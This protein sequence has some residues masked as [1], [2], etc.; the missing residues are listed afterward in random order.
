MDSFMQPSECYFQ[1]QDNTQSDIGA[2]VDAAADEDTMDCNVGTQAEGPHY[3]I[4]DVEEGNETSGGSDGSDGEGTD[5]NTT[6]SFFALSR[7]E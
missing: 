4:D 5:K 3:Y 6:G 1:S 2:D 7:I